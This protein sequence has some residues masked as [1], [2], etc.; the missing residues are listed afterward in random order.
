[1][2]T[3]SQIIEKSQQLEMQ[4]LSLENG[5]I[6]LTINLD[7]GWYSIPVE[8]FLHLTERRLEIE[9]I[10]IKNE[11]SSSGIGYY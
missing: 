6:G 11:L 5:K 7:H 8:D 2:V 4:A 1:M 10:R 3:R 9:L